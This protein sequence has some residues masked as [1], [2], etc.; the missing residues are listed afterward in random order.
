MSGLRRNP[1][2]VSRSNTGTVDDYNDDE[3]NLAATVLVTDEDGPKA[4]EIPGFGEV[5]GTRTV[6]PKT[7]IEWLRSLSLE[8]AIEI[9]NLMMSKLKIGKKSKI[10][11][12]VKPS[13][14]ALVRIDGGIRDSRWICAWADCTIV[15]SSEAGKSHPRWQFDLNARSR[16]SPAVALRAVLTPFEW[17]LLN[18]LCPLTSDGRRQ[19]RAT[20]HHISYNA[21]PIRDLQPLPLDCGTG[22]SIGHDCDTRGCVKQEHLS[23]CVK[24]IENLDRQRCCGLVLEHHVAVERSCRAVRLVRLSEADLNLALSLRLN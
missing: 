19:F 11:T 4:N 18:D 15:E 8:T 24:H 5:E 23:V 22:G 13:I 10:M 3:I 16:N 12:A 9:Y 6:A 7:I 2:L 21:R 20:Y 17:T 1:K 14:R